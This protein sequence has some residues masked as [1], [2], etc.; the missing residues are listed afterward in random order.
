MKYARIF[1]IAHHHAFVCVE[2]QLFS[3]MICNILGIIYNVNNYTRQI[4]IVTFV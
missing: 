4:S 2:Y 3:D 1:G